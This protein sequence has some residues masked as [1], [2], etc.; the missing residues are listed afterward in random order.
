MMT[1]GVIRTSSSFHVEAQDGEL[2]LTIEEQRDPIVNRRFRLHEDVSLR[3]KARIVIEYSGVHLHPWRLQLWIGYRR[4]A[5]AAEGCAIRRRLV[6]KGS[7]VSPDQ[8]FTLEEVEILA[9]CP[10]PRHEG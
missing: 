4:A 6:A 8:L 3:S 1:C 5:S 9:Q 7:F 10:Q 2:A